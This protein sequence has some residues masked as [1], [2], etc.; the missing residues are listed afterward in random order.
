[1]GLLLV[2]VQKEKPSGSVYLIEPLDKHL[3]A[4]RINFKANCIEGEFL[5]AY[6]GSTSKP[7]H[8]VKME[9]EVVK[10]VEKITIDDFME[11]YKIDYVDV[12][13]A[14]VQGAELELLKGAEKSS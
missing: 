9:G 7:A 2:V 8:T 13:H 10:N 11:R 6:V 4:G 5:K 1:L 14:D 12:L 3:E